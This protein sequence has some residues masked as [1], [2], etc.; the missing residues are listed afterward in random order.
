M[1]RNLRF[2]CLMF[3]SAIS[4]KS[5]TQTQSC[6]HIRTSGPNLSL[7]ADGRTDIISSVRCRCLAYGLDSDRVPGSALPLVASL[8]DLLA[9][10][11][12]YY[13]F[14]RYRV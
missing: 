3:G 4:K 8:G 11:E 5:D 13:V 14:T 12:L 6:C 1:R 7:H 9:S 10:I 2:A